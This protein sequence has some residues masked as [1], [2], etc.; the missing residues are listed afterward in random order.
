VPSDVTPQVAPVAVSKGS[1]QCQFAGNNGQFQYELSVT[2]SGG[3]AAALV[4]KNYGKSTFTDRKPLTGLPAGFVG[5]SGSPKDSFTTYYAYS[6]KAQKFLDVT[7]AW[8]D[9]NGL[10]PD[11]ASRTQSLF[12]LAL[13]RI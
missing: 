12:L 9:A 5:F 13:S 4:A 3:K 11:S 7:G 10:L 1:S 8:G 6:K 2:D